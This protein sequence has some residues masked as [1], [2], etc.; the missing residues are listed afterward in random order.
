MYKKI[1]V[2]LTIFG[3]GKNFIVEKSERLTTLTYVHKV[4]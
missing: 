2:R 3:V 1:T 4:E